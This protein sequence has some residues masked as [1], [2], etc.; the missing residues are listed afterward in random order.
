[1]D[2]RDSPTLNQDWLTSAHTGI[3]PSAG[4]L[5]RSACGPG[6]EAMQS[7]DPI[8]AL[9]F[10]PSQSNAIDVLEALTHYSM[11]VQFH[12]TCTRSGF[13]QGWHLRGAEYTVCF[14]NQWI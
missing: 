12:T 5:P 10:Q 14:D 2:E 4:Q 7:P 8:S 1:M 3:L 6:Y 11:G 13:L 9:H